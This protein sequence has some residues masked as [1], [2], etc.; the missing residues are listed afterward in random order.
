MQYTKRTSI[1]KRVRW[2]NHTRTRIKQTPQGASVSALLNILNRTQYDDGHRHNINARRRWCSRWRRLKTRRAFN[3][4]QRT[5]FTIQKLFLSAYWVHKMHMSGERVK[6]IINHSI[7]PFHYYN[8]N[9]QTRILKSK[10]HILQFGIYIRI[11][12]K[13]CD[14]KIK[15]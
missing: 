6:Y 3:S 10:R 9:N 7:E 11:L 2:R 13:I 14:S 4:W 8:E 15:M 1:I 12:M 5:A